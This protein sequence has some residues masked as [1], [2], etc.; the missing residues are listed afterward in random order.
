MYNA[1]QQ[2]S[3]NSLEEKWHDKNPQASPHFNLTDTMQTNGHNTLCVTWTACIDQTWTSAR[4]N[5][6]E[7]LVPQKEEE[8]KKQ[9]HKADRTQENMWIWQETK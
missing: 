4:V 1:V 3:W 9:A 2:L 5:S 7:I 6:E 8:K